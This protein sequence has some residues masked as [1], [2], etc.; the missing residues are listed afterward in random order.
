MRARLHRQ[1]LDLG[2]G[3]RQAPLQAHRFAHLQPVPLLLRRPL[4]RNVGNGLQITDYRLQ[5]QVPRGIIN[6]YDGARAAL[7]VQ[8]GMGSNGCSV[9][10]KVNWYPNALPRR[11]V[12]RAYPG[13]PGAWDSGG[14]HRDTPGAGCRR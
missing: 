6:Y 7:R 14:G 10:V 13:G 2:L 11:S 5:G 1:H 9:W 8:R 3:S 4:R 12:T